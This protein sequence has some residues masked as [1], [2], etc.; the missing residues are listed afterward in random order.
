MFRIETRGNWHEIGRQYGEA[1]RV[2]L[3]E[4]VEYFC[5]WLRG[6]LQKA[7]PFLQRMRALLEKR[8]PALLDETRGMAEGA[9]LD[10][11]RMLAYRVFPDVAATMSTGCSLVYMGRSDV[12]PLLARNADLEK[13]I[14]QRIQVCQ[15]SR[16]THG[17]PTITFS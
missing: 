10:E 4:C 14:S 1:L 9:A 13:G 6:D 5:P 2:P 11:T 17:T 3:H 15:V 8:C 7:G 16:P 12:G